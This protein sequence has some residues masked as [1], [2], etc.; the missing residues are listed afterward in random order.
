MTIRERE[1]RKKY[2][3]YVKECVEKRDIPDP[4]GIWCLINVKYEQLQPYAKLAIEK[5]QKEFSKMSKWVNGK[6]GGELL[7]QEYLERSEVT[8]KLKKRLKDFSGD[9]D[10]GSDRLFAI[11]KECDA[12]GK[13]FVDAVSLELDQIEGNRAKE[14]VEQTTKTT[15]NSST[16]DC[17][18][19][20]HCLPVCAGHRSYNEKSSL[21]KKKSKIRRALKKLYKLF[22]VEYE[23][24]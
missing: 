11:K 8:K 5:N 3:V 7:N 17:Y 1:V 2:S 22:G 24:E 15:E 16:S 20:K 12:S 9:G 21:P 13:D 4:F 23:R 6:I 18:Y 10:F 19:C 14:M